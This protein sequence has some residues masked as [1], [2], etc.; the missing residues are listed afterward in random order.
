[1]ADVLNSY[2]LP[3]RIANPLEG[4]EQARLGEQLGLSGIVLSERWDSKELGSVMGALSQ[5][6]QRVRLIAGITHFGTR[7][8]L[9]QA[10]MSATMQMLSGGRFVLGFGRSV[11]PLFQKLGIPVLNNAGMTDYIDILRKLWAGET[12]CYNGPAGDYPEM[13]LA[14][15]CANPPPIIIGAVGPKT[16]ALAGAHFDG[17]LLHPFLTVEGVARSVKIVRNAARAAGRDPM[18]TRIYAIVVAAPDTLTPA[19]RQNILEARAVSY[20]MHRQIGQPIVRMN[21]WDE[22]PMSRLIET[23]LS[24]FEFGQADVA[25]SRRQLAAAVEYL[26]REW[27]ESGAASGSI[28]QCADRLAEY[29]EAGAD[30][31]LLHGTTPEQQGELVAELR[32]RPL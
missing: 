3:G 14:Q 12:V 32:H 11:P 1:M 17:I 7:H 21:E 20:F 8:P 15:P 10:G 5:V 18:S 13:E 16:L 2:I 25:E 9:V 26:P 28:S 6:T 22:A 19:Q 30:E 31:I 4:L 23:G 24:K 27:L 29:L